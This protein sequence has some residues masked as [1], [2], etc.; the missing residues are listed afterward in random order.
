[1]LP[2]EP[3]PRAWEDSVPGL[4]RGEEHGE[5][6][7]L[8]PRL[9][10]WMATYQRRLRRIEDEWRRVQ[11]EIYAQEKDMATKN[12]PGDYDCYANAAPDEPLF[13]LKSTDVTAP[14][15]V[16][17]WAFLRAGMLIAAKAEMDRALEKLVDVG[18]P[19]KPMDDPK[20]HEAIKCAAQMQAWYLEN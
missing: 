15:L 14:H 16:R 2:P 1:M 6:L 7:N 11:D 4:W 9:S 5:L 18:K 3:P 20:L 10:A 17:A 13:V 12:N 8:K 19:C